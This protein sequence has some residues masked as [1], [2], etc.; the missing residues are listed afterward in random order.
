MDKRNRYAIVGIAAMHFAGII[1]AWSILSEPI[2]RE[3]AGVSA[4]KL[5]ITFTLCMICFCLGGLLG[6]LL[7]KRISCKIILMAS[8][9]L[10]AL[11][12]IGSSKA[13]TISTIYIT[14]GLMAGL[15]SGL[16]YNTVLSVVISWFQDRQG[17]M[18]GILLMSFG[19]GSMI[20]GS[21]FTLR[22]PE[23]IGAWRNT[24]M[25]LAIVIA[26][27][28]FVSAVFLKKNPSQDQASVSANGIEGI[29]PVEMLTKSSFWLFFLWAIL[30]SASGLSL[31]SQ[32]RSFA[33]TI[34]SSLSSEV[35]AFIVGLI[36]I[37][38][39]LGRIFFGAVFD[40]IGR[41]KTMLIITI[42]FLVSVTILIFAHI[43]VS[44]ILMIVAFIATGFSYGGITPTNSV[45]VYSEYGRLYYPQNL[46]IVNLN[47]LFASFGGTIAGYL[48]D[49][50]G[51]YLTTFIAMLVAGMISLLIV[52]L[53]IYKI[54]QDNKI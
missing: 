15:A 33:G 43:E 3:F 50:S 19:F 51:S 20:L 34:A 45:F 10:F 29:S 49:F 35:I 7:Q 53:L 54:K 31:I 21:V 28:C 2:G 9:I 46:A 1:Y 5:S 37:F 47:L 11:G 44:I 36:S 4:A 6:S 41:E 23:Q 30:L 39:G 52:F 22:T 14:Y 18:S 16:V 27:V 48:Y 38:N 26:I 42:A 13:N 17:L 40:R 8:G 32:A 24:F 25:E 12:F